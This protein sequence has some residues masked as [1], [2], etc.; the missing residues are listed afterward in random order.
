[1]AVTTTADF[2]AFPPNGV[3][4][5]D[6]RSGFYQSFVADESGLDSLNDEVKQIPLGV[7][8][9]VVDCGM[10]LGDHDAGSSATHSLIVNDGTTDFEVIKDATTGQA[11]GVVRLGG[12]TAA[13]DV[14][15]AALTAEGHISVKTTA[16]PAT[17]QTANRR[18]R[19]WALIEAYE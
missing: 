6:S 18:V 5:S 2:D 14:P 15:G 1:M 13:D 10:D 16:A 7:G 17:A 3:Y 8:T 11:G 12:G 9:R 4:P 19:V